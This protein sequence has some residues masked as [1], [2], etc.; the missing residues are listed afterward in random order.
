MRRESR[1]TVR[2]FNILTVVYDSQGIRTAFGRLPTVGKEG[3]KG[4]F[5]GKISEKNSEFK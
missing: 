3:Q 5:K 1:D 2:S 4:A